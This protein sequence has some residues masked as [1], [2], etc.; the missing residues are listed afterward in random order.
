MSAGSTVS[1]GQDNSFQVL[2]LRVVMFI[3][4]KTQSYL[5]FTVKGIELGMRAD[6]CLPASPRLLF[7]KVNPREPLIYGVEV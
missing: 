1:T 6:I 2:L 3:I 4:N 7:L 5:R